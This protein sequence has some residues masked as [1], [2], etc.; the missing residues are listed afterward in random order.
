MMKSIKLDW[1][2]TLKVLVATLEKIKMTEHTFM[3]L[4]A[5]IIGV[6]AGLGAVGIRAMIREISNLTFQGDGNLLENIM[7]APWYLLVLAPIVGGLLTGPLIHYLAPE[8]KGSGVPEVVQ[9][10]LIEGGRIRPRVAL[11]KSIASAITIG[12]GGS[13]GREGPII[14]IGASLASSVGQVFRLSGIRIKTLVG[15]GAAAGIAAAFNAPIAGAMFAVEIILMNFAVAQFSPI[16][17]SSV[18]A[19]VVSRFFEGN[20]VAFQVPRYEFLHPTE[21][22]FYSGLGILCGLASFLFIKILFGTEDLVDRFVRLPE[23]FKPAVGGLAVGLIALLFPQVMGVGYDSINNALHG[24]IVWEVAIA[25]IFFKIL[26]T[27]CTLGAGGSGGVFAP[28]LFVGAMLGGSFGLL[29][30]LFFPGV[31]ASPGAYALVGMGGIVAGTTRAPITAIVIIFEITNTYEIIL[32]LMIT[33]IISTILSSKFSRE[34]IYTMRLAL[35]N[36]DRVQGAEINILRSIFVRDVFSKRL[37]TV[38]ENASFGGIIDRLFYGDSPYLVVCDDREKL[39]GIILLNNIRKSYHEWVDLKEV[40]IAGD[41][42]F[43][44]FAPVAKNDD[45]QLALDRMIRAKLPGLPVVDDNDPLEVVGMVWQKDILDAYHQEVSRKN[46]ALTLLDRIHIRHSL[47]EIHFMKGRTIAELPVPTR[48]Y[49]RSIGELNVRYTYAVD[50]LSIQKKTTLKD[51]VDVFPGP[52][53][54]FETDDESMTVA[55]KTDRI[56]LIKSLT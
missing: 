41:I 12:T 13:V 55:G 51:R 10:V 16:V 37:E 47:H 42:A 1:K 43:T 7:A 11:V 39:K 17:I 31:A 38:S 35:R 23:F 27:S 8:A 40:I 46:I 49:G 36:I 28:S 45:C 24:R 5:I 52:E 14:Q 21:L 2:K 15:C 53:R 48:F 56:N 18:S 3:I 54:R 32:P 50:I 34:S 25:L 22:L 4:V 26:A 9:S 6:L 33:C 44:N 30:N 19:T 29:M 20:F